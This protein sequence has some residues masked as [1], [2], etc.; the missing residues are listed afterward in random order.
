[1]VIT[2]RSG[3]GAAAVGS[4]LCTAGGGA[5]NVVTPVLRYSG[6]A[7]ACDFGASTGIAG[8]TGSRA[9]AGAATACIL[10]P[11]PFKKR[12]QSSG[13]VGTP[14]TLDGASSSTPIWYNSRG[15]IGG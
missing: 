12:C 3:R 13:G 6:P 7:G 5:G 4:G 10:A 14:Q 11:A 2:T 1:E 9:G 15:L 8:T